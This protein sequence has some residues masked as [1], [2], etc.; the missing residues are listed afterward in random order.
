[1]NILTELMT[2]PYTPGKD[3]G[4]TETKFGAVGML[5]CAD[6][7]R[8]DALEKMAALK[9]EIVLIPYGWAAPEG[10]WPDHGKSLHKTVSNAA[11]RIG[12]HVIGTDGVG[13]ITQGPWKGYVYGG[14]SV[15]C[16]KTGK[17]I[18]I[19]ADRDR[20]IKIVTVK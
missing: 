3:V 20:D 14:Q 7:F 11:K 5:I 9:P 6:T 10:N 8:D 12:A 1:M 2:P 15:A 16:D 17:I 13:E 19:A 18:A 4:V